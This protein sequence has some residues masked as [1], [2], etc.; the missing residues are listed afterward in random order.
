MSGRAHIVE[1]RTSWAREFEDIAARLREAFGPLALRIDHIGSTSV[2]G[3]A[4]KD[5]I[6]VQVTVASVDDAEAIDRAVETAGYVV[7]PDIVG[8]HAPPLESSD[9]SDWSKRYGCERDGERRVHV[10]IREAGRPN[11]RYALLF[12]DYLRAHPEAAIAYE[13]MKRYLAEVTTSTAQYADIKD[14]VCDLIMVG[15]EAWAASAAWSVE[16]T[17]EVSPSR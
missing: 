12:R 8:D 9:P 16:R 5:V 13:R 14:A 4:A 7:R 6:D 2:A 11:Q 1:P 3:L 15:A 10:H 17:A